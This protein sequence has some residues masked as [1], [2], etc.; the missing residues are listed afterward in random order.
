MT[1]TTCR[2]SL[3]IR[4]RV[5]PAAL[6]GVILLG[7]LFLV[8][9]CRFGPPAP[10]PPPGPYAAIPDGRELGVLVF[11][12][13]G[14]GDDGQRAL[15]R[16]MMRVHGASP[17][18]LVLTV[19]DN[20]YPRGI[21]NILDPQWKTTF[22]DVYTGGFWDSVT[23][24]PTF[25]NHDHLGNAYAQ[26]EYSRLDPRWAMPDSFYAFSESIPGGGEALFIAL[27]TDV[28]DDDAQR[29]RQAAWLDSVA[30]DG[31][32]RGV[33]WIVAYGHHP[34]ETV[35]NHAPSKD[36]R[37]AIL[38]AMQQYGL[39][40]LAG[41]NHSLELLEI[42]PGLFTGVCGGG[43]GDDN[44]MWVM[45]AENLVAAFTGGGWCFLRIW[46]EALAIEYYNVEGALKYRKVLRLGDGVAGV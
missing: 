25:G 29:Q 15:A 35:G 19:G 45:A 2:D 32:E 4:R 33:D 24:R 42:E 44:D 41:H 37:E 16:T 43:G 9:G 3:E 5:R 27:D 23:F 40:Y 17:P 14:T 39:L 12:D 20:F 28:L 38:P 22:G 7:L 36:A 10:P 31:R 8:K 30:A 34:I 13:W 11:G 46:E 1:P 18:E 26:I 21:R 6:A